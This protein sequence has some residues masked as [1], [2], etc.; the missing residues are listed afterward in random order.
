MIL[1]Q[2]FNLSNNVITEI[3]KLVKAGNTTYMDAIIH[4]AE[5]SGFELEMIADIVSK[6]DLIKSKVAE[7]AEALNFLKKTS[8]LPV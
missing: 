2:K 4:Y 3:N 1:D 7:E 8:R 6:N 5:R